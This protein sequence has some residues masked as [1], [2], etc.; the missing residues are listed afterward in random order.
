MAL[1]KKKKTQPPKEDKKHSQA[2]GS[3]PK[4][5]EEELAAVIA[6]SVYL[7]TMTSMDSTDYKMTIMRIDRP[8]SPWSSKNHMMR[9][10]PRK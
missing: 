2:K 6:A 10:W 4:K 3:E 9:K 5:S 7:N 8:Y 1:L